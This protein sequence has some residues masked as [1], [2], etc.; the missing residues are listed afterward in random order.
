MDEA[1]EEIVAAAPNTLLPLMHASASATVSSACILQT[2]SI[3]RICAPLIQEGRQDFPDSFRRQ[4][5]EI[6]VST[7]AFEELQWDRRVRIR[8]DI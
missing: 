7:D 4:L 5:K 8:N 6:M 1:V 2:V 3:S